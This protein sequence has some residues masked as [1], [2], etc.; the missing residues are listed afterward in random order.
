MTRERLGPKHTVAGLQPRQGLDG[1]HVA[2]RSSTIGWS[3]RS[4]AIDL[5]DLGTP[6]RGCEVAA[7]Q[8]LRLG[9]DEDRQA[10]AK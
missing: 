1:D 3:R 6:T 2:V 8:V 4:S 5:V 10:S 9:L 7:R